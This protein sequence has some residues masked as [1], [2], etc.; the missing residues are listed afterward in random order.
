MREGWVEAKLSD[1]VEKIGMGPFGSNIKVSTFVAEGVPI[2]SGAHLIKPILTEDKFNYLTEEHADRLKGSNVQRGD[3]VLTH[4]GTVGQVSLIPENSKYERYVVSQ[5][6]FYVRPKKSLTDASYLLLFLK[7][8]DGQV[9]LLSNINRTGVPSLSQPVT[10]TKQIKVALPPI[11]EQK[12]IVNVVLSVDAY[13][14]ALQQQVDAVRT[15]RNAVL[16]ELLSAGGDDWTETTLGDECI[17]KGGKRLPKGTPWSD[18][19]TTHPYIRATDFR[20]GRI[21]T[22]NL[23]FVPEEIWPVVSRYVIED[24][25][26]LITIA[27]T[28]GS[29]ALAPATHIGA[30]LTE[31]AALIRPKSDSLSSNFLHFWLGDSDAQTQIRD[32]TIGTTQQKLGLFRIESIQILL[33][34]IAEQKRIV[35]IVS[36]MDEVIQT[37]ERAVVEAK[38]LRSGLLSDLLSGEHEIP[39]SYD[40]LLGAA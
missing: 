25:D 27:G 14:D 34:P 23:V 24:G 9:Q 5:R 7:Y 29:V 35:E 40:E 30:N 3:L 12:R 28:I 21:D 36:S 20:N 6:G 17:V 15:A 22:S 19:P 33:P 13:I 18:I 31:N 38:N 2:I 4:A 10:F 8:G 16:H 37:A 1:L 32:L 39:V 26:V 11:A